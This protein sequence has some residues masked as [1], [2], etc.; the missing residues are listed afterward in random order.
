VGTI[1]EDSPIPLKSWL[2]A[3][4][5]IAS[6]KN[7]ISSYELARAIG[8]TQKSAWFMNHRIRLA[9]QDTSTGG[10]LGG[11]VEVDETFIGGKARNMHIDKR[12]ERT[13][14]RGPVGKAAVMG[15]LQRH[16]EK[17]KSRV[18][19]TVVPNIRKHK[20]HSQIEKHVE[21]GSAVYTDALKSYDGLDLYYQHKVIDHAERYV[22]GQVHTN[23]LE[24]F[25]SLLK[26]TIKGTYVSVEPF[27]LFRYLDE[28]AFR[29]QR[30]RGHRRRSLR[31]DAAPH[32]RPPRDVRQTDRQSRRRRAVLNAACKRTPQVFVLDS[33]A[34]RPYSAILSTYDGRISVI[35]R[36]ASRRW[37]QQLV[38][39]PFV[40]LSCFTPSSGMGQSLS[41]LARFACS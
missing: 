26:R 35:G 33:A 34:D 11:T 36:L 22:D 16:P 14:G 15:L 8:V 39:Q 38:A 9:M 12:R 25:W 5:Q 41:F 37:P 21:D 17:G 27:H 2:L 32:R 4:W 23:G 30:A 10:K 18:R 28:Q 7:G 40:D 6:C 3:M 24:N 19:T 20:L 1:F 13:R 29:F 31:A